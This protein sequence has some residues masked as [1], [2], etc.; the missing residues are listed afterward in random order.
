MAASMTM[1]EKFEALMKNHEALTL[2]NDEIW[3]QNE[4]L[5]RQLSESMKQK[6]KELR[7]SHSSNSS[8]SDQGEE[9][10]DESHHLNSSSE[11]EPL[12]RPRRHRRNAPNLGDIKVEVPEFEERLDSDEFLK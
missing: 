3:S 1:D 4:Y 5:K 2:Q 8:E 10:H 9:D 11:E 7:S 12:R 6:R